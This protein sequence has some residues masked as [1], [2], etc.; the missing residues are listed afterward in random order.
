[1]LFCLSD[2]LNA[3]YLYISGEKFRLVIARTEW[4]KL[5]K[6]ADQR[7]GNMLQRKMR[8]YG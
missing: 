1:M 6:L 7:L 3:H 5:R 8:V 4:L 2:G